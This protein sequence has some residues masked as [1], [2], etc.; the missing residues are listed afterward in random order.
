MAKKK[1]KKIP[2]KIRVCHLKSECSVSLEGQTSHNCFKVTAVTAVKITCAWFY[3][4]KIPQY[5]SYANNKWKQWFWKV[6]N[7]R[8]QTEHIQATDAKVHNLL[9]IKL[10]I[11]KASSFPSVT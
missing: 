3:I 9:F 4:Q 7:F 8:S 10:P 1:K 11:V 5:I 6:L 2:I